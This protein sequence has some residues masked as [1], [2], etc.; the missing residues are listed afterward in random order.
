KDIIIS[1]IIGE[2]VAVYFLWAF[3]ELNSIVAKFGL[4]QGSVFWI[5]PVSFPIL[6]VIGLWIAYIIGKKIKLIFQIAKYF[7]TGAFVT[8]VDLG[9]LK[10]LM[11]ISGISSGIVYSIFKG[12]SATIAFLTKFFGAKAWVFEKSGKE[13]KKEEK[14]I[15][16]GSFVVV[17]V[18]GIVINVVAASFIVNVIPPQAQ[19]SSQSWGSVG[20]IG[21]AF[22]SY[23]W[24]FFGYKYF[25]FK[26]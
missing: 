17:S 23:L 21:G 25:V 8:L 5:L 13:Q 15:E 9:I 10:F 18:I 26:K 12:S 14:I 4:P 22:V 7:L 20:G 3:E 6:A 24:N 11:V 19:L 2:L 16:F 1:A